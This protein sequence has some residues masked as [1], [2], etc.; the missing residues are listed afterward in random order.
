MK[1][2][3][4]GALNI[5]HVYQL[6]HI[7]LEGETLSATG[8]EFFPGGKGFNQGAALTC[9]GAHT[10][11]AGQIGADG[12]F[13]LDFLKERGANVDLVREVTAPTGHAI[14]QIDQEGR[15]CIIIYGGANRQLTRAYIDSV[16]SQFDEGDLVLLQNEV[17]ELAYILEAAK[18]RG[19]QVALNPS[20]I[21]EVLSTLDYRL[22]DYLIVNEIEGHALTNETEPEAILRSLKQ[23]YPNCTV[24]LTLGSDG[25][26]SLIDNKVHKQAIFPTKVVDTTAAGDTYA[27]Y[28]LSSLSKGYS[29]AEAMELASFASS[30]AVSRKG[31]ATSVP[32]WDE[33]V[34]GLA[35]AKK[36]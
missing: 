12:Q 27:A 21:D 26:A 2:L 3:S 19:L 31:A 4:F 9:S 18:K 20:P 22:V 1:L 7:I 16:F 30:L 13:M 29:L 32:F 23:R 15:N 34:E 35:Q 6:P 5:D 8:L 33:V 36:G 24:L 14:I 25:S 10:Y 11:L 28:V 17:N